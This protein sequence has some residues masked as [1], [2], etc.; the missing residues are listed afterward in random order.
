MPPIVVIDEDEYLQ[1]PVEPAEDDT[2]F[3]YRRLMRKERDAILTLYT[4]RGELDDLNLRLAYV[5]TGLQGWQ[6]LLGRGDRVIAFPTRPDRA[7]QAA[8]VSKILGTFPLEPFA[9]NIIEKLY[10][11][12]TSVTQEQLLG[13]SNGFWTANGHSLNG[14]EPSTPAPSAGPNAPPVGSPSPATTPAEA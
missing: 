7:T 2:L 9:D 3:F 12:M 10:A 13:N 8:E 4:T 6:N 14:T 5:A 11:A 1:Y